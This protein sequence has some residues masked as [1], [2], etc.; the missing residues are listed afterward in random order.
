MANKKKIKKP[1]SV[2]VRQPVARFVPFRRDP[3]IIRQNVGQ[4]VQEPH[5]Q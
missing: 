1:D 4:F 2:I 3:G 5:A